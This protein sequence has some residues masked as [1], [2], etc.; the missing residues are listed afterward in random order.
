MKTRLLIISLILFLVLP[1]S[2]F[3][4][5]E[6][7]T[8]K[9]VIITEVKISGTLKATDE[10]IELFN[11][12]NQSISLDNWRLTKK[13]ESG[14]EY[15]LVTKFSQG[16][17]IKP[18]S[19]FLVA[20]QDFGGD[21]VPDLFYS[22][23]QSLSENNTIVL[24]NDQGV[25]ML[26]LIGLGKA[27]AFESSPIDNPPKG[28]SLSRKQDDQRMFIDTD[29]N[30]QDFVLTEQP[31]P[32][33]SSIELIINNNCESEDQ[34]LT[35]EMP[36]NEEGSV[37]NS[38][39]ASLPEE[40]LVETITV[41]E[42]VSAV[43]VTPDDRSENAVQEKPVS[44]NSDLTA[45]DGESLDQ[46]AGNDNLEELSGG[47]QL[48]ADTTVPEVATNQDSSTALSGDNV[49]EVSEDNNLTAGPVATECVSQSQSATEIVD[50]QENEESLAAS[51]ESNF[52]QTLQ[53]S[54]QTATSLSSTPAP[55]NF[56]EMRVVI[57]ELLPN[58]V[59]SDTENE[60]IELRN[61]SLESVDLQ[62]W[63]LKDSSSKSFSLTGVTIN[64]N[65]YFVILRSTSKIALN[66]DQDSVSLFRPDGVLADNVEYQNA[67]EEMAYVRDQNDNWVWTVVPT[68]GEINILETKSEEEVSQG[69]NMIEE[70]QADQA[71]DS[72][73]SQ[74][75]T[76]TSK[77]ES[78][79]DSAQI[80]YIIQK[81][82]IKS[83]EKATTLPTATKSSTTAKQTAAPKEATTQTSASKTTSVKKDESAS[84]N[85][86]GKSEALPAASSD[87]APII[88][89]AFGSLSLLGYFL[90][91]FF[92]NK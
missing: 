63:A 75:Q 40:S 69:A 83:P 19:F 81:L 57:S 53:A 35:I 64:A 12:T 80:K 84:G 1:E 20:H 2:V 47:D 90:Y 60:W 21:V 55:I 32:E 74:D 89:S 52:S 76:E 6:N 61:R 85:Q 11:P 91:K 24:Y 22:T 39:N 54:G 34:D 56:D 16:T 50:Q 41:N 82:Y 38:D 37:L 44:E 27:K 8:L 49:N 29:N 48:A 51:T 9:S 30:G 73:A 23:T 17:A 88:A 14:T 42:G 33:N 26:D 46:A 45:P 18:K 86:A 72:L 3:A 4:Q 28:E 92:I 87:K 10:F 62:G 36:G 77:D 31:T 67:K 66:N 65:D 70:S 71:I 78:Q 25:T 68:P 7:E 58:P 5:A 79:I 13:T 15:N 59:G 43:Q